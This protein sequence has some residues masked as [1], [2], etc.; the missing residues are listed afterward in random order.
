MTLRNY[1]K[2]HAQKVPLD[3]YRIFAND[4]KGTPEKKAH[5]HVTALF[6][7][8]KVNSTILAIDGDTLHTA[9]PE[10]MALL[11]HTYQNGTIILSDIQG[12]GKSIDVVAK[13]IL[14]SAKSGKGPAILLTGTP[15][16]MNR[17][18]KNYCQGEFVG[19]FAHDLNKAKH[20][21]DKKKSTS[22]TKKENH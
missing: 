16:S 17:F 18:V 2:A 8:G 20:K 13:A 19:V 3:R 21:L 10:N 9:T 11:L 7:A 15:R 12:A 22:T 14:T 5:R 1:F 6:Q 4:V